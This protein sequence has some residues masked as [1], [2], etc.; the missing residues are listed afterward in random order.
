MKTT[1]HDQEGLQSLFLVIDDLSFQFLDVHTLS[2]ICLDPAN[3]IGA[4][5]KQVSSLLNPG[6]GGLSPIDA[7]SGENA[8]PFR[9][10]P[11]S[12]GKKNTG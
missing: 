10:M 6:M 7:Y 2:G 12:K 1:P 11:H 3:G 8:H 5:T 9:M 4:K